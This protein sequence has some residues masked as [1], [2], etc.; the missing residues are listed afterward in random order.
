MISGL[1]VFDDGSGRGDAP[2]TPHELSSMLGAICGYDFTWTRPSNRRL[3][4]ACMA[5]EARRHQPHAAIFPTDAA[6]YDKRREFPPLT[7]R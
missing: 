5:R 6:P 4:A 1:P 7:S 3:P 2:T